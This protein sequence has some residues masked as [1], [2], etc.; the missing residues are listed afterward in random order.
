MLWE[1][2]NGEEETYTF[3]DLKRETNKFA[4]ALRSLGVVKGDRV[5]LFMERVPELYIAIFGILKAHAKKGEDISGDG[6]LEILVTP[7]GRPS[8]KQTT[9]VNVPPV[10]IPISTPALATASITYPMV[11]PMVFYRF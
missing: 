3:A 6:V 1:G 7:T 5:F 11:F 10:S 9:S 4:N 8:R 2:K